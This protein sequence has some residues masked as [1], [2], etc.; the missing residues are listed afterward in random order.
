MESAAVSEGSRRAGWGPTV[1]TAVALQ[2]AVV[3]VLAGLAWIG[4]GKTSAMSLLLGG[5]S[6]ALPNSLLAAWL[7]VRIRHAGG[8]GL[9]AM[10]G[11]ELL[12]VGLTIALLVVVAKSGPDVSMLA[13]IIGVIV[14]LKAQWLALWFTRNL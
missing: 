3:V 2:W 9:V 8:A 4:A 14:A 13:L 11:G 7:T 10:L 12:K 5:A 1:S 6:V